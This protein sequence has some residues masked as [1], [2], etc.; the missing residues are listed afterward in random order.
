MFVTVTVKYIAAS[1]FR[2]SLRIA[3]IPT[4]KTQYLDAG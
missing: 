2:D 1:M 4:T 3:K